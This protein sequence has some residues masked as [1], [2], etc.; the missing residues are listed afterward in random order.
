MDALGSMINDI[1]NIDVT[2]AKYEAEKQ[3]KEE[4]K[5]KKNE[6]NS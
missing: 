1:K 3:R 2:R 6:E 5:K 4:E